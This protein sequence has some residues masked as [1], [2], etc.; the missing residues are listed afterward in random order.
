VVTGLAEGGAT[1]ATAALS[2]PF[3]LTTAVFNATIAIVA[4]TIAPTTAI[5][6]VAPMTAFAVDV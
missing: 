1:N 3:Y 2:P 5:V 6:L 4:I